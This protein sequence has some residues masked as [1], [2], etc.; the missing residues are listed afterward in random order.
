MGLCAWRATGY[1]GPRRFWSQVRRIWLLI[2]PPP[3]FRDKLRRR[4]NRSIPHW[5]LSEGS[6]GPKRQRNCPKAVN[7]WMVARR[8]LRSA[9][10][11]RPRDHPPCAGGRCGDRTPR[12]IIFCRRLF[13]ESAAKASRFVETEFPARTS[14][15]A[16]PDAPE[17]AIRRPRVR[18]RRSSPSRKAA[19]SFCTFCVVA[20]IFFFLYPRPPEALSVPGSGPDRCRRPSDLA[21]AGV[22]EIT[23]LG[24][25]VNAWHGKRA[26]R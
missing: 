8:R 25:N 7:Y 4:K 1:D 19:T 17:K 14:S 21:Q 13:G 22:R 9:Q 2:Q 11:R 15:T 26:R 20:H 10:R 3:A 24:Q 5:D 6:T 12:P 18:S 16:L 23:L